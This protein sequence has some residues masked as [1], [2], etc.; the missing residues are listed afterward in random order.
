MLRHQALRTVDLDEGEGPR[1]RRV[2]WV[3][4]FRE[5]DEVTGELPHVRHGETTLRK[6]ECDVTAAQWKGSTGVGHG[7][8][9]P[10]RPMG[11]QLDD[12]RALFLSC[13]LRSSL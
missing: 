3:E 4:V 13:E 12:L 5:S 9:C 7:V 11:V 2:H 6:M 8:T 1:V 10:L